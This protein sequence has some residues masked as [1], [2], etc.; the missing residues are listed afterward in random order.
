[1]HCMSAIYLTNADPHECQRWFRKISQ[2]LLLCPTFKNR[3]PKDGGN[4]SDYLSIDQY[5]YISRLCMAEK[6]I[7]ELPSQLKHTIVPFYEQM[8]PLNNVSSKPQETK[9][10]TTRST[11]TNKRK[12][13]RKTKKKKIPKRRN[14]NLIR[15]KRPKLLK[16]KQKKEKE[17]ENFDEGDK[18]DLI[19]DIDNL[20]N[21]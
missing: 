20:R 6:Q 2:I 3:Q 12:Q 16:K 9:R 17:N 19:Q 8:P 14:F 18:I 15:R 10:K 4:Y 13:K 21:V 1:M 11:T 7:K 5:R